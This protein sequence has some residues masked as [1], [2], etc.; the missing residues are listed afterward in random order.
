[1]LPRPLVFSI[2]GLMKNYNHKTIE[3][4][5]QKV[6]DRKKLNS[7]KGVSR[8]RKYYVLVEFPYPSGDGL[9]TGHIRSYTAM[10]VVARKR[11]AEG[12]NVLYPMG[13]DAFGLPTENYAIK[14]GIHP[15]IVTKKNTNTFKRQLKSLGFSFDWD[16]EINTTDPNYFRWTQW[17]FLKF[18][19]NGLAYKAKRPINWCLSCK[20]GLA[21]EEIVDGKC[22][23]CGGEIEKRDKEQWMLKITKYA[24]KLHKDLD[25]VDYLSKI[26]IQ[27]QNW[28]GKSEGAEIDFEIQKHKGKIK[29]FTT[30][31]DTLF[32]A[33]A[34]I[35]S[36]EHPEIKNL[37]S[38]IKNKAE[39]SKYVN[40][41]KKKSEIER[42][43]E[44]KEKTGVELMGIRAINPG[45][46]EEIP[47][48]IADYVLLHYGTGALMAVPA[49]DERDYEFAKKFKIPIKEVIVPNRIDLKNPPVKGKKSEERYNV[50]AIVRDPSTNKYLFMYSPKF[51]W[52]TLPMG[53]VE[54]GEDVVEAARRE[55]R[56]EAGYINLKY[57]RT[58]G[59]FV[60]AEYFAKH[61]NENR[62]AFTKAV[63][64]D[65]VDD[66]KV[67]LSEDEKKEEHEIKWLSKSEIV[68]PKVVHAE[69]NDWLLRWENNNYVYTGSGTLIN[70]SKFNGFD[71]ERAKSQIIKFV[72]GKN[73]I[74][75]KL[76]D[77]VFSRQRYW[78][79]PI[80]IIHCEK[81]GE[82]AVPEKNLP[83]KLP[84]VK[85]YKPTE[86]GESPLSSISSWVNVKC[87]KCK[88]KAKRETDVMPNWAGS[89]WYFLR[90]TDPKNRKTFAGKTELKYWIPVDWYNGGMEHT[91]LHLLYSRFW[92]KFLFDLKL[93]PTSEPYTK[94]TSHG[95]ILAEG[96][97]KMS[98][99]KGNVVNPDSI[100][101]LLGADTLRHYEMFMGPFDQSIAWKGD[102]L[103][104][105]RR[106]LERVWKLFD[107][108]Q[109]GKKID[110]LFEE[111]ID[112]LFHQTIKKVSEDIED[113]K[114]NTALS[115]MMILLNA[116]E[117][118]EKIPKSY[119]ETYIRLLAP[120]TPHISEELWSLLG[121][122]S[123]VHLE[124]WPKWDKKKVVAENLE[125]PVQ[126]NGKVRAT[127]SVPSTLPDDEVKGTAL[128]HPSILPTIVG[129]N[130][131]KVIYVRGKIIN[132]VF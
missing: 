113:L 6:W 58:L 60:R 116:M 65:L 48:Y 76:R 63:M 25:S 120:F 74:T 97:I 18:F 123:S 57:I 10:D 22:E 72:S 42:L 131:R 81:C 107:K 130:I 101:K 11:R 29:V 80:P 106:F 36:P 127:I 102:T 68:Y 75:Y 93:V 38:K 4:K 21:D 46:K 77:W 70:S 132:I 109:N 59:G 84:N 95:L 71:S 49:H 33:T 90:Y 69:L 125:I 16:R 23:R 61:K 37:E 9:H 128:A 8:K 17:I 67:E 96:G 86:N 100:V 82:V 88:G 26:K 53:G 105:S 85:S 27:Q 32:G 110:K 52:T 92:H 104:G 89:S 62:V 126:I 15:R 39:V 79:E 51:R 28:I 94:R 103:S 119:F 108:V 114:M 121:E 64:F 78:G 41:A 47:I 1:M 118:E 43:S 124:P 91:T 122:R 112:V 73:K 5:W 129:K 115:Q 7:A 99:S 56:E 12:Y 117:K 66:K 40:Q 24:E 30:R 50:H 54:K 83:V 44:G 87:P 3:T 2:T 98:K 111:R 13:W 34:L 35:L 19:E 55:V 45:N 20:I 14:T 31:P